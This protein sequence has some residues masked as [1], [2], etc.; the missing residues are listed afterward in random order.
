MT[1]QEL[2]KKYTNQLDKDQ[3]LTAIKLIVLEVNKLTKED[4]ILNY[5]KEVLNLEKT[6]D[7]INKYLE[8]MPVQYLLGFTYFYGLKFFVNEA[9]LIPRFDSEILIE[10]VLE[11]LDVNKEYRV[12]D[13]GTGSGNLAITLKKLLPKIIIDAVDI[14][15][16]AL[17]VARENAKYH[18]VDINFIQSDLFSNVKN[19]YDII[20]SNP[21]Y[22]RK[23]DLLSEYVLKEPIGALSADDDGLYYYKTILKQISR[24]LNDKYLVFFEVGINQETKVK[25]YVRKYLKAKT[26]VYLDLNLIPRVVMIEG[27]KNENSI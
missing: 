2:F 21:P 12:L 13:I 5:N 10:A 25:E 26:K 18:K 17:E 6:E 15:A 7:L 24:Y 16:S 11:H 19:K 3:E 14:S 8:G 1:Y 9:V 4:L 23:E 20:I 22:V 27:D